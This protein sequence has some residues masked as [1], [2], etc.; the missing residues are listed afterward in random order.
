MNEAILTRTRIV[1]GKADR[2]QAWYEELD[3]RESEVV[4]TLQHEGVYTESAFILSVDGEEYLYG[5]MEAEDIQ[6][7]S[8][9]SDEKAYEIDE[10]HHAV[11]NETLTDD[12]ELLEQIGHFTNPVQE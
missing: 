2:L 3:E 9:A 8:E 6:E 4:E 1:P 10:E 11:L 7:A 12:W 5:Y